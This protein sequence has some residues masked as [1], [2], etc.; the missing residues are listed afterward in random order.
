MARYLNSPPHMDASRRIP[1]WVISTFA[2]IGGALAKAEAEEDRVYKVFFATEVEK[3][4]TNKQKEL[5]VDMSHNLMSAVEGSTQF[6]SLSQQFCDAAESLATRDIACRRHAIIAFHLL[7]RRFADR[8]RNAADKIVKLSPGFADSKAPADEQKR[9]SDAV[10]WAFTVLGDSSLAVGDRVGAATSFRR[11]QNIAIS[12]KN[13]KLAAAVLAL[14]TNIPQRADAYDQIKTLRTRLKT[15]LEGATAFDS[16]LRLH[17]T[18]L[19][20]PAGLI[21]LDAEF[22]PM[23]IQTR[24]KMA[25]QPIGDLRFGSCYD[26]GLWY[27]TLA[28]SADDR[29]KSIAIDRAIVYF[30]R[31]TQI[32]PVGGSQFQRAAAPKTPRFVNSDAA[33]E[34]L[35]KAQLGN[36]PAVKFEEME[37]MSKIREALKEV[38]ALRETLK[39]PQSLFRLESIQSPSTRG[40]YENSIGMGFALVPRSERDLVERAF[41]LAVTEVTQQQWHD[42]MGNASSPWLKQSQVKEGAKYPAVY[43]SWEE[44]TDFCKRLSAAHGRRYRLPYFQEWEFACRAGT[45]TRYSFGDTQVLL[46][47][48]AWY[49]VNTIGVGN[50]Y[51]QEVATKIVNPWGIFDMHGN[52]HEWCA[53]NIVDKGIQKGILRGGS[54]QRSASDCTSGAGWGE[55]VTFKSSTVGF[56]IVLEIQ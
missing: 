7:G 33:L 38:I 44:A 2:F 19:D 8:R 20:D 23:D 26:L 13:S 29:G 51:A 14:S 15:K 1:I 30:E 11:A 28:K 47:Q 48:Y 5:A 4:R 45:S 16:L 50:M 27:L 43:V 34:A 35:L 25:S 42:V 3:V 18:A 54:W 10:V 40:V 21:D 12:T 52:V 22:I 24:L 37:E 39:A 36:P 6:S 9:V 55:P 56:R 49:D 53:A 46:R 31:A 32:H 41:L 17:M